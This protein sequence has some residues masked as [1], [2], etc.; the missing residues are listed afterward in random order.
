MF[1]SESICC[2]PIGR[3]E[4]L[5]VNP[6]AAVEMAEVPWVTC[7]ILC[8]CTQHYHGR[9]RVPSEL[10]QPPEGLLW[11][12]SA[13]TE[14]LQLVREERASW[15]AKAQNSYGSHTV[16]I[17]P[18][19]QCRGLCRAQ[20]WWA[21]GPELPSDHR[22]VWECRCRRATIFDATGGFCETNVTQ[23]HQ[24]HF[25]WSAKQPPGLPHQML[26]LRRNTSA[27]AKIY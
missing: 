3:W 14:I 4:Q 23:R 20:F 24:T 25:L 1:V 12:D 26:V 22:Y 2:A 15:A 5:I 8:V 9:N 21:P 6:L 17:R 7:C 16:F 27:D 11:W 13:L 18:D 19:L 10:L